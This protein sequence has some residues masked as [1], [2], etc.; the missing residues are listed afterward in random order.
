MSSEFSGLFHEDGVG[1][2]QIVTHAFLDT[3]FGSNL[4]FER[5]DREGK[6]RVFLGHLGEES[7]RVLALQVILVFNFSLVNGCSEVSFSGLSL[8]SGDHH[9]EQEDISGHE[10]A[11]LN[12]SLWVVL[13]GNGIIAVDDV[14]LEFMGEHAINGGALELLTNFGNG[15]SDGDIGSLLENESLGSS[16]ASISTLEDLGLLSLEGLAGVSRDENG[17]SQGSNISIQVAA[18]LDLG[19]VSFIEGCAL[20]VQRRV[21]ADDVVHRDRGGESDSSFELLRLLVIK[22]F[23]QF[24]VYEF[25][26]LIA[27]LENIF[28]GL[29]LFDGLGKGLVGNLASGLIFVQNGGLFDEGV[30]LVVFL[31]FYLLLCLFHLNV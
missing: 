30:I 17:V 7:S 1:G 2:E 21:V 26:D 11:L 25:V 10:F 19:E 18:E 24:L 5:S 14:S 12:S 16:E 20:V 4:I 3:D 13:V 23:S 28:S 22:Y 27:N 29:A 31:F 8:T 9:L 6:G 15:F